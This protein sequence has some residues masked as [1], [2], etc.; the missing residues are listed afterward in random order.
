MD[1]NELPPLIEV[2]EIFGNSDDAALS[3][4]YKNESG[5]VVDIEPITVD[6]IYSLDS[7]QVTLLQ[8][9]IVANMDFTPI[10]GMPFF[11]PGTRINVLRHGLTALFDFFEHIDLTCDSKKKA[12]NYL[13][14][15]TNEQMAVFL[16][17]KLGFQRVGSLDKSGKQVV[18]GKTHEVRSR[19]TELRNTKAGKR[20][21]SKIGSN[22]LR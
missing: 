18:L 17:R 1:S 4:L 10:S 16:V 2:D 13:V 19:F 15:S 22:N 11:I 5:L 12:P 8:G 9:E 7:G 21:E 14:G 3:W 20:L 6:R